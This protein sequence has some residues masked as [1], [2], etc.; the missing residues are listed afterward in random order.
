[1]ILYYNKVR[2]F[3]ACSIIYELIMNVHLYYLYIQTMFIFIIDE[4]NFGAPKKRI[5]F[6]VYQYCL[7]SLHFFYIIIAYLTLR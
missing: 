1:M 4:N 6:L 5:F 3:K 2:F 7:K